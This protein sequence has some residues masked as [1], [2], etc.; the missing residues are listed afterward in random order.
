VITVDDVRRSRAGPRSPWRRCDAARHAEQILESLAMGVPVVASPPPR[1]ASTLEPGQDLLTAPAA[2]GIRGRGAQDFDD[3]AERRRFAEAGR[4]ASP[5]A[6]RGRRRSNGST[7]A[8]LAGISRAR[9]RA[10]AGRRSRM[11][12]HSPFRRRGAPRT[13][14]GGARNA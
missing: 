11:R 2:L 4:S 14:F 7:A 8:C 10:P 1:A 12:C 13:V 3:P 6:I 9:G 5:R